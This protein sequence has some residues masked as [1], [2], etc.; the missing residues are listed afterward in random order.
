V[1]V[2]ERSPWLR[3]DYDRLGKLKDVLTTWFDYCVGRGQIVAHL[4]TPGWIEAEITD[5]H[6]SLAAAEARAEKAEG[7]RDEAL[8]QRARGM[9]ADIAAER[10]AALA[11]VEALEKQLA[12]RDV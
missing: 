12:E 1:K 11:H 9:C 7:E 2:E 5:L 10:D 3:P 4:E 6:R 8:R